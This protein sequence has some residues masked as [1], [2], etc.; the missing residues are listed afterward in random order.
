MITG[1]LKPKSVSSV[2]RY[3]QQHFQVRMWASSASFKLHSLVH[4]SN[5]APTLFEL[6]LRAV[7]LMQS[8]PI[9]E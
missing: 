1:A 7:L 3:A 9:G 5:L 8:Y 4:E 2:K 6:Q